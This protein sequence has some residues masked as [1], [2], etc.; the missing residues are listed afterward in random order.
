MTSS[1]PDSFNL[2][3]LSAMLEN[4]PQEEELHNANEPK[5]LSPEDIQRIALE[6]INYA[7]ERAPGPVVHKVMVMA[8]ITRMIEWHTHMGMD[9]FDNDN[10]ESGLCWLRDAGKFQSIMDSLLNIT[11]GDDDFTC[12]QND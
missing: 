2:D 5:N 3:E 8:I 9:M 4:A 10:E 12:N 11:V 7:S 6:A 1:V